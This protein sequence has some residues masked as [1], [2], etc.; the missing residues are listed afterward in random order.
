[1]REKV[2]VVTSCTSAYPFAVGEACAAGTSP[3]PATSD[4][5]DTTAMMP[6]TVA[7]RACRLCRPLF[8]TPVPSRPPSPIWGPHPDDVACMG[9]LLPCAPCRHL[10]YLCAVP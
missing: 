5:S 2:A 1:M 10:L 4:K 8:I 9:N 3:R 6:N 7:L